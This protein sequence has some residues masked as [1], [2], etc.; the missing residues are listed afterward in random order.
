MIR[1]KHIQ[2][3]TSAYIIR[4][5]HRPGTMSGNQQEKGNMVVI[6]DH[7]KNGKQHIK[8]AIFYGLM[9]EYT[10]QGY[11]VDEEEVLEEGRRKGL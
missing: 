10:K 2:E 5:E 6:L 1:F 9:K 8:K 4:L 7:V 3:H 11:I